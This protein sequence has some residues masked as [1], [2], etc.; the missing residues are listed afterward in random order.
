MLAK[1]RGSWAKGR[2]GRVEVYLVQKRVGKSFIQ[3]F[4][5]AR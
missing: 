2:K 5:V 4:E 1:E 3:V